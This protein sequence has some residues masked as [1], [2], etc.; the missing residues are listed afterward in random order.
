MV[1]YSSFWGFEFNQELLLNLY[2]FANGMYVGVFFVILVFGLTFFVKSENWRIGV[3]FILIALSFASFGLY[4]IFYQQTH[5]AVT[6]LVLPAWFFSF[7]KVMTPFS[8]IIL[9]FIYTR[10]LRMRSYQA[11]AYNIKNVWVEYY[12]YVFNIL[13]VCVLY[14]VDDLNVA[15]FIILMGF[16][17]TAA[18]AADLSY[19]GI[20]NHPT[21]RL[22]GFLFACLTGTT[23]LVGFLTYVDKFPSQEPL[24]ILI[25]LSS[26][27][28]T[29]LFSMLAIRYGYGETRNI[30]ALKTADKLGLLSRLHPAI[31]NDEFVLYYQPQIDLKTNL[32]IGAEALIRWQHPKKGIISPVYFIELAEKAKLIDGITKW[33]IKQV[34]TDCQTLLKQGVRLTFSIN[35][36]VDSL[37]MDMVAFL[38]KALKEQPVPAELICIEITESLMINDSRVDVFTAIEKIKAMGLKLSID[39]YGTGFSSLQYLKK[40]AV[41]ELKIDRSFVQA[42]HNNRNN[43]AIVLSTV[44]MAHNLR[45]RTVAE[46]VETPDELGCLKQMGCHV[47]QGYGLGKPMAFTTFNQ[48]LYQAPYLAKVMNTAI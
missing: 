36:S 17:P 25:H 32:V 8:L 43:Y 11:Y 23:L 35:F 47:A 20:G 19:N 24:M 38:E 37:N 29:L 1:E 15:S 4:N 9:T 42:L 40:I 12:L 7:A 22:F 44:Q 39:D 2:G 41:N 28:V 10:A 16:A 34:L 6:T 27:M 31:L 14:L 33:V 45:L 21:G 48:W 3:A 5:Q 46:G 18:A 26:I 30:F 13:L